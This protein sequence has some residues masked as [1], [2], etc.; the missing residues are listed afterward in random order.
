[1]KNGRLDLESPSFTDEEHYRER[2]RRA[3]PQFGDLVISREAPMGEVAMIPDGLRACL[4][5]RLVLLRPNPNLCDGRFLLYS[6]VG[7]ELR[8]QVLQ[9]EGTGSTVSNL[10]IPALKSLQIRLP[11]LP[12]QRAIAHIL[13]TLDDKIALNRRTNRTL[14]EIARALFT[15]W[16]VAFDP[17]RA[18]AAGR[19]PAGMDAATAAL[20][21]SEFVDTMSGSVPHGWQVQK[22]GDL[23]MNSRRSIDPRTIDPST[24]YI[25]LEH[26]PR[27]SIALDAWDMAEKLE[28][29]KSRF[30]QGDV[31]FGKLR[32]YFHKVG[33]APVGGV[34]STDI[35]VFTPKQ[36]TVMSLIL[37]HASSDQF[38]A[39][40]DGGSH[41]TR[42]PR[43]SWDRLAQY[44][45]CVPPPPVMDTFDNLV[46]SLL[47]RIQVN[48]FESRTLAALRDTLLPRLLSGE[49]RGP[50][51][52]RLIGQGA[53]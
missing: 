13:G 29:G 15:S 39:Y 44:P 2:V 8:Q 41:G 21:P 14:E 52:E 33:V 50:H 26:M 1:L 20:F 51:A 46:R 11:P 43:A 36:P 18:K 27:R 45:I 38:I 48:I 49:L 37:M 3:V 47:D 35:L 22:F 17:V 25:G 30:N 34:C 24:P 28:S 53:T 10:R 42:M 12:E 40:A 23:A 6:F 16:F 7:G 32:P 19:Q 9:H 31:L 5:Q 4:G